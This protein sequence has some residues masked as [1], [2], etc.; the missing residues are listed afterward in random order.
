LSAD[1][2]R[3]LEEQLRQAQKME[4][5]GLLAGGVS[6]DFS[7][8]LTV[9]LVYADL[10]LARVHDDSAAVTF[11][12]EI[13]RAAIR[14]EGL[15]RQWRAVSRKQ[16][17]DPKTLDLNNVIR[18]MENMLRPMIG[19]EIELVTNMMTDLSCIKADRGQIEQVLMNL[20]INARDAMPAGG[21]L[22]VSTSNLGPERASRYPTTPPPDTHFVV[23]TIADTGIGIDDETLSRIFEPFFTTK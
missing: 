12:V 1:E 14:A 18:N 3:S 7:N 4:A 21:K 16:V 5:V 6:H 22:R 23:L 8:L 2:R 11:V 9:M 20:V 13:Q 17:L 19:E 10:V 15:T